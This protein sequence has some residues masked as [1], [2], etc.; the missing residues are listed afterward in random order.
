MPLSPG[1]KRHVRP[2]GADR[3]FHGA[4]PDL[5]D[6]I[7]VGHD[8]VERQRI[9]RADGPLRHRAGIGLKPVERTYRRR[10][11]RVAADDV[12]VPFE[13]QDERLV[14]GMLRDFDLALGGKPADVAPRGDGRRAHR[15]RDVAHDT[16]KKDGDDP[17]HHEGGQEGDARSRVSAFHGQYFPEMSFMGCIRPISGTETR[18]RR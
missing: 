6:A 14:H 15:P 16:R 7:H 1:D 2:L 18:S 5:D 4:D 3:V 11:Y 8:V 10:A 13:R 12:A 17:H 9:L